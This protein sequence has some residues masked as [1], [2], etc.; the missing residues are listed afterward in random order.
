MTSAV[1]S[2]VISWTSY[3]E[4]GEITHNAVLKC[5]QRE[6]DL[7]K[8]YATHDYDAVLNQFYAKARFY[9]ADNR[10]FT[11]VDPILCLLY[12]SRPP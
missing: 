8:L 4:W 3:N 2:K 11:A 1:N 6:L 7:V 9:D 12:T 5:G 10:R